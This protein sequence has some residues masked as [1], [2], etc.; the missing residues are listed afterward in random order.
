VP[1]DDGSVLVQ[2]FGLRKIWH[3]AADGTVSN[4]TASPAPGF[5]GPNGLSVGPDGTVYSVNY[6]DGSLFE[7]DG[8]GE[9]DR[10]HRF[11]KEG[12]HVAYLD[13]G[14]FVT[15]R[16]G[17]VVWRYDLESGGVEIVAGNGEPGDAD[18]R[19]IESSFGSPNAIMVG[20]DGHLYINHG[21]DAQSNPVTIRRIRHDPI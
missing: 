16:T 6:R 11:P 1:R 17:Y 18:G 3:V 15:S 9:V 8:D 4:F 7:I 20:P 14:L 13:G 10:L 21:D 19:G 12:A 5:N 2:S